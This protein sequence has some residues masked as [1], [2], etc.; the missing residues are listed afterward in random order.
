MPSLI[1][2]Y[3]VV[4]NC[5]TVAL[6]GRDGSID[7]LC[8]P[9]FD[10]A[11]C[12]AALLGDPRHGRWL[13]A[14]IGA[15]ARVERHY[16]GDTLILETFFESAD[17]AVCVIDFMARREGISDLLR[18]VR[19]IRGTVA[20]LTELIVRFEYGSVVPWVSRQE[21]GRLELTAGPDRPVSYTHLRAH[22]TRHDL[23]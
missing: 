5:E 19:G 18:V 3:A 12:F 17:G 9:R 22:E 10:S 4:G 11:A 15:F 16:R 8:S 21:D 14:P 20:M 6:V 2:D 23:V 1:E 7:W 13:I